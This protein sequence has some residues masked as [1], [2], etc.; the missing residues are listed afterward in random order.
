MTWFRID[1]RLVHGQVIEGWLPYL[2]ASHLVVAN[3][4]LAAN[5]I[6]QGIMR[7]AIPGRV[8]VLFVP[9]N[10]V[11]RVQ[12][13]LETERRT[14][15]FLL[16]SCQ[17]AVRVVE[18]GGV[19]PLLNIGNLHYGPGKHQICA[20][21]AISDDDAA[22]LNFFRRRGTLLDFRCV[23]TDVPAVVEGW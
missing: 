23:P 6:Q 14:S 3:D 19:I 13:K 22:C 12:G 16:A 18:Q 9:V 1:N 4:A 11:K 10:Q 21:V 20:H 2:D 5:E 8:R 17:D 15:L 7:L